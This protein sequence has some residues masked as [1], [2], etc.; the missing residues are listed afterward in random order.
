MS[1]RTDEIF[2][3]V[4]ASLAIA[5]QTVIP[6]ILA[7]LAAYYCY[8]SIEIDITFFQST[9]MFIGMLWVINLFRTLCGALFAF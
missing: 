1:E 8:F 2:A 5:S 6:V 4:I 9:F 3:V 7:L